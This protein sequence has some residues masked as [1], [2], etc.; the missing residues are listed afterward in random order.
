[1]LYGHFVI[2][3]CFPKKVSSYLKDKNL[4]NF[5]SKSSIQFHYN[6]QKQCNF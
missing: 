1:M 6:E 2:S 5:N 4:S 3:L